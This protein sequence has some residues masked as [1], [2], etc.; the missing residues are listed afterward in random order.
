MKVFRA[1]PKV[2]SKNSYRFLTGR[3]FFTNVFQRLLVRSLRLVRS[4]LVIAYCVLL[5]V[6]IDYDWLRMTFFLLSRALALA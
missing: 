6:E 4:L 5:R 1:K 3:N 2:L